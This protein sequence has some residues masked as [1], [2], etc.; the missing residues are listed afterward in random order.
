MIKAIFQIDGSE[1]DIDEI[2]DLNIKT[3]CK[4]LKANFDK[5]FSS[6]ECKIHHG[7]TVLKVLIKSGKLIGYEFTMCCK[8]FG[9]AFAKLIKI[10]LPDIELKQ[11][12][13]RVRVVKY[14]E[15]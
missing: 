2:R 9:D 12:K 1:L 7:E 5:H 4:H 14:I 3:L 13:Y 8:A 6:I 10:K 15:L 11:I